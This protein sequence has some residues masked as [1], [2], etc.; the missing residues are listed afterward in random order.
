V[1]RFR[2]HRPDNTIDEQ[3]N[4]PRVSVVSR[5]SAT[6][7]R[8]HCIPR[9]YH[10]TVRGDA[11]NPGWRASLEMSRDDGHDLKRFTGRHLMELKRYA[12]LLAF[13]LACFG[14]SSFVTA[15]I[16]RDKGGNASLV[17]SAS[18][19][20]KRNK[21]SQ[22]S[23]E[24]ASLIDKLRDKNHQVRESAA[25]SLGENYLESPLTGVEARLA[26]EAL[27]QCLEDEDLYVR[28]KA[29]ITL[30]TI[31]PV[32]S[33][34]IPA[35]LKLAN[36]DK[37]KLMREV[38]LEALGKTHQS[39]EPILLALTKGAED[40]DPR[41]RMVSVE[42]IGEIGPSARSAIPSLIRALDD[43]NTHVRSS[44]ALAL[45]KFK[46]TREA[47]RPLLKALSD[48]HCVTRYAAA[49][50]IG[51]IGESAKPAIGRLKELLKDP[52][53]C[54]RCSAAFSIWQI[55]SVP[56]LPL[57]VLVRSLKDP[58]YSARSNAAYYLAEMGSVAKPAIP[59]LQNALKDNA[60]IVVRDVAVALGR[61]GTLSK[62]TVPGLIE[63]LRHQDPLVR[64]AIIEAL[65]KIDPMSEEVSIALK[66]ITRNDSDVS[67]RS[68]A[69]HAI[70]L[71]IELRSK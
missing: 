32:S 33:K 44:A 58:D 41:I 65:V 16:N 26:S 66:E 70:E 53:A 18:K 61:F 67:V 20:Q 57:F 30:T 69:K 27:S 62:A 1:I 49:Y 13:S 10:A 51:F 5:S 48:E 28:H 64:I 11:E 55:E 37:D 35:L 7:S 45:A 8:T 59:A 47:L 39:T 68:A 34:A 9:D 2:V 14:I 23:P 50:A 21:S 71:I 22:P 42:A 63:R 56:D 17:P 40:S 60:P 15:Q 3:S 12:G 4:D 24:I 38:A 19:T 36:D 43:R 29:G 46:N 54:V 31:V 6:Q 25:F 52:D